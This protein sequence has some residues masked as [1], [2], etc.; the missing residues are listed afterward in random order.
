MNL[1]FEL[2]MHN[3]HDDRSQQTKCHPPLLSVLFAVVLKSECW[4]RKNLFGMGKI[5]VRVFSG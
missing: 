5:Q 3:H 1:I 4:P 2:G